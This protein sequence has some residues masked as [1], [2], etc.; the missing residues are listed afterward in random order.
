[1]GSPEGGSHKGGSSRAFMENIRVW[2]PPRSC[3]PNGDH[4]S[5]G[6]SMYL[7]KNLFFFFPPFFRVCFSE[8]PDLSL[9]SSCL[10]VFLIRPIKNLSMGT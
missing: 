6:T 3:Q 1:M 9:S 10:L 5:M 4:M 7:K 2:E 8:F